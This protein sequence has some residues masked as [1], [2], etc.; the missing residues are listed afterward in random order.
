MIDTGQIE[1]GVEL[2]LVVLRFHMFAELVKGLVVG[3]LFKMGEFMDD[4]HT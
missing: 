3:F 4:D 2:Q 1:T